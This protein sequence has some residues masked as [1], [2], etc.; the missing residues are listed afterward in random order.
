MERARRALARL[1]PSS[2]P[3]REILGDVADAIRNAQRNALLS[4]AQALPARVYTHLGLEESKQRRA[5]AQ[6]IVR[7]LEKMAQDVS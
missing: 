7:L 3:S 4:A 2:S 5:E 6:E 1:P